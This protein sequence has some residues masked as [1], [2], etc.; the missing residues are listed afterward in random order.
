[1]WSSQLYAAMLTHYSTEPQTTGPDHDPVLLLLAI[2]GDVHL[3]P[4]PSR[5]PCSVCFKNVTSHGT[6]Y[7]CTICSHWVHSR[8]S[9]LRN[10]AEYRKANGWIC[11]GCMTPPQPRAPSPPPSPAHTTTMS[12]KRFNILQWNANGIGNKQTELSIFLEAHNVKVATIQEFNH[13]AKSRSPNIQ[14]YTLVRQDQCQGPGRGLLL[15]N[16]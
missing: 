7:L 5:Y 3:N 2:A 11:N 8:W 13:T 9:G 10:D 15:F 1:M 16:S 12:D 14:N 6:S 4:R